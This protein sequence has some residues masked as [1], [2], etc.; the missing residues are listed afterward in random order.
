MA[1]WDESK[2]PRVPSGDVNGGQFTDKQVSAAAGAAREAAGLDKQYTVKFRYGDK[3]A[4][5]VYAVPGGGTLSLAASKTMRTDES[6]PVIY[7]TETNTWH[8]APGT[9]HGDFSREA[10]EGIEKAFQEEFLLRGYLRTRLGGY[11]EMYDYSQMIPEIIGDQW[12]KERMLTTAIERPRRA[13]ERN[14]LSFYDAKDRLVT[15]E[16]WWVE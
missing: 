1:E 4:F 3:Q 5:T 8:I 16:I 9:E 2:H 12:Q 15:P 13:A 14:P 6:I 7:N 10:K 11:I